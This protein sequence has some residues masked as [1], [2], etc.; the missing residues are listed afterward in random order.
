LAILDDISPTLFCS[1]FSINRHSLFSLELLKTP[2]LTC[3][4]RRVFTERP[5]KLSINY[6]GKYFLKSHGKQKMSLGISRKEDQ[7]EAED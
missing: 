6:F 4:A 3:H 2:R 5:Q 7:A 1:G